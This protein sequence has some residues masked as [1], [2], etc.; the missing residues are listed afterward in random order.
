MDATN[1]EKWESVNGFANYEISRCGLVRNATTKRIL[2]PIDNGRG[3]LRV[4]LQKNYK[5]NLRL[6]HV[7]L[8]NALIENPHNKPFVDHIDG[9]R[10]NNCLENL[11]FATHSENSRNSLKT[12]LARSSIYKG[13]Y[14]NKPAKKWMAYIRIIG[15]LK[16]LGYY[17]SEREA[18][19]AYNA[20]AIKFH[21][22]FAR[23]N[24]F[25][26]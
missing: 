21:K 16:N 7:L 6:I 22:E 9:N 15:R 11:R 24:E 1:R 20:A 5:R 8:A 14:L 13:V 23:I 3:Y 4:G 2:T 19:E 10:Q 12:N 18:G 25:E 17:T 26:N